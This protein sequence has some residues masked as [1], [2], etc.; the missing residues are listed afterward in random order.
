RYIRPEMRQVAGT[1]DYACLVRGAD[2]YEHFQQTARPTRC[3]DPADL[4]AARQVRADKEQFL[5]RGVPDRETVTAGRR[6]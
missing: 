5:Y 2:P 3:L 6:R 1:H 4:E